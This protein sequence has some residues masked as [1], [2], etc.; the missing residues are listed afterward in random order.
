MGKTV[1]NKYLIYYLVGAWDF[2]GGPNA[3]VPGG[4]STS[5]GFGSPFMPSGCSG[6]YYPG[7]TNMFSN[8]P[9]PYGNAFSLASALTPPSES[10]KGT[11]GPT[12]P[13]FTNG[14]SQQSTNTVTKILGSGPTIDQNQTVLLSAQQNGQSNW[15]FRNGGSVATYSNI[16]CLLITNVI[17]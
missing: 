5:N 17:V 16:Q 1:K 4:S 6:G 14:L 15:G 12:L 8:P 10:A 11:V 2:V 13:G 3:T 7:N 9:S